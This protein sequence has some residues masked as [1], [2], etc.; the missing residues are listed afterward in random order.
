MLL[1]SQNDQSLLHPVMHVHEDQ[2]TT[3]ERIG[4]LWLIFLFG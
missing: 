3:G 1:P 4:G 2:L